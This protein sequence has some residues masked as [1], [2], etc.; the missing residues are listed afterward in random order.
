MYREELVKVHQSYKVFHFVFL[1]V[2]VYDCVIEG[3]RLCKVVVCLCDS[4]DYTMQ[5]SYSIVS[6]YTIKKVITNYPFQF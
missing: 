1:S 6:N 3:G 5:R 2:Y 4:Y